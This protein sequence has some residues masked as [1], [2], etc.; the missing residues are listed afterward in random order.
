M[1]TGVLDVRSVEGALLRYRIVAIVVSV[2]LVVLFGV[3][4]PLH[5][6]G[7]HDGVDHVVGVVH[8]AIFFPI[9]ILLTL[10]LTRRV[11][12][13]PVQLV[14]T[15]LAGAVPVGSFYAER[16]TTRYVRERQA[17]LTMAADAAVT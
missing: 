6:A 1:A 10:D 11:R 16:Y 9:Y 17:A 8:G 7:G 3:G 12:M 14:L 13:T 15:V 4:L 5:F 2:L